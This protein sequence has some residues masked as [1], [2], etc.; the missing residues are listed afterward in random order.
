VGQ[1]HIAVVPAAGRAQR[2]PPSL[3]PKELIPIG[4]S[5]DANGVRPKLISE[6]LFDS[7]RV[8][9]VTDVYVIVAPDK[10]QIVEFYGSGARHGVRIAYVLQEVSRGMADAIDAAYP[11]TRDT[12]VLVG[13]PDTLFQPVDAFLQ[14]KS[15]FDA[16]QADVALGVFPTETPSLLGPVMFDEAGRVFEVLEKP[17]PSPVANTW[18]IAC[19]G[20]L[21]TEFLHAELAMWPLDTD[22]QPLGPIFHAAVDQG[23]R[24]R[25]MAFPTGT[26]ID[27][28]TI[29]GLC[30][31]QSAARQWS[32]DGLSR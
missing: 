20:P 14:L 4:T 7:L 6:F 5:H 16:G 25:A 8:A 11:S 12:T 28:G 13:M 3:R 9:D 21:F 32:L 30:T 2:L 26:Y 15:F 1:S 27:V 17:N 18:G 24:V 29:E 19:W 22:E 31:A 10:Q 23:L